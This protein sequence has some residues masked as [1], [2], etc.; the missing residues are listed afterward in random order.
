[1]ISFSPVLI[2][3]GPLLGL[4]PL[5]PD[6]LPACVVD[7]VKGNNCDRKGFFDALDS[8]QPT[9]RPN[10]KP[11]YSNTAFVILGYAIE[12]LTGKSYKDVLKSALIDPLRLTGTSFSTPNDTRGVI[13]FNVSISNWAYD[14][15]EAAAM[16]GL[17]S[18]VSDL[19]KIGRSILN[20]TLLDA[21]T[22]RG[23]LKPTSFTSSLIGAVGRPWEIYRAADIIPNRGVIDIFS[24]GGDVGLYHTFLGL[25]PD[26]NIGFATAIG[27]IGDHTWLDS[28]IVDILF[29]A[30]EATARQQAET[31]FAGTYTATNGLNTTLILTTDDSLPGLGITKWISNGTDFLAAL[32]PLVGAPVTSQNLRLYPTNLERKNG[33]GTTEIAWRAAVDSSNVVERHGPFSACGSWF[34]IDGVGYGDASL[35]EIVFTLDADGKAISANPKAFKVVLEREKKY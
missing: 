14:F 32:E 26:Y 29:P 13:P 12:S 25:V 1:M 9:Y 21:N 11:I 27:G 2:E 24:K 17:Y 18:S 5:S 23:W 6:E 8:R 10:T 31:A 15:G 16:G 34:T 4:P 22:T 30:L 19:T 3:Q 7:P 33:N 20:S 35:D 28:S